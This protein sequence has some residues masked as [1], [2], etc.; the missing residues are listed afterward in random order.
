M[1]KCQN[2]SRKIRKGDR[3]CPALDR[4]ICGFCCVRHQHH[5]DDCPE[6]CPRLLDLG[7][8][9]REALRSAMEKLIDF[10]LKSQAWCE[11]AA[12]AFLGPELEVGDWEQASFLAYLAHGHVDDRGQRMIDRFLAK[13]NSELSVEERKALRILR[14]SHHSLFEVQEVALDRGLELLDLLGRNRFFVQEQAATH[15]LVKYDLV[16]AWIIPLADHY[17]LTG[18]VC[19]VP[20]HHRTKVLEA[21]RGVLRESRRAQPR[22]TGVPLVAEL[23]VSAHQALRGAIHEWQSPTIVTSD[24]DELILCEAIFDV[25]DGDLARKRLLTKPNIEQDGEH[26][27]WL[28]R[29]RRRA[30]GPGPLVLG[31]VRINAG[32]MVLETKSRARLERGKRVLGRLLGRRAQHRLDTIQDLDVVIND[33]Q[34]TASS[35][36]PD[37][38][39]PQ[40]VEAKLVGQFMQDHLMRWVD[41]PLPALRGKS[42]RQVVRSRRGRE[43]VIAMLK[44]QEHMTQ[45]MPGGGQVDFT[46]VYRELGLDPSNLTR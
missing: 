33:R 46:A 11:P 36:P 32:R 39:L 24:G 16:L 20:R 26:L 13:K 8:L 18:A 21:M 30:L 15:Q 28:D 25:A 38:G 9:G 40:D 5:N 37:S 31:T 4:V 34:T 6:D 35:P 10:T 43:K 23:V 7:P 3:T 45:K 17:E 44:D 2:C 14:R 27:L 12:V 29:R 22:V 42:P 19:G 1:T 41:M